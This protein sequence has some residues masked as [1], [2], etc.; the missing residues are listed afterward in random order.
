MNEV[1]QGRNMVD[2]AKEAGLNSSSLGEASSLPSI[3][4]ISGVKYT[5]ILHYEWMVTG[6]GPGIEQS[7]RTRTRK[8]QTQTRGSTGYLRVVRNDRVTP[9]EACREILTPSN[10]KFVH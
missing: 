8:T 1:T 10:M 4:K 9:A 3:A 6:P 5:K 2:A 7:T